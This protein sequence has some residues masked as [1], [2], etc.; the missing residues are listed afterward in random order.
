MNSCRFW[1]ADYS[2]LVISSPF[3]ALENGKKMSKRVGKGKNCT[4]RFLHI[5][6][7]LCLGFSPKQPN[8]NKYNLSASTALSEQQL[9]QAFSSSAAQTLQDAATL[10]P[11]H[12]SP[13]AVLPA[14]SCPVAIAAQFHSTSLG[15]KVTILVPHLMNSSLHKDKL[16]N[17]LPIKG[18]L[19]LID[20]ILFFFILTCPYSEPHIVFLFHYPRMFPEKLGYA[21]TPPVIFLTLPCVIPRHP[22]MITDSFQVLKTSWARTSLITTK[23]NNEVPRAKQKHENA[24]ILSCQ[25]PVPF[26]DLLITC[27]IIGLQPLHSQ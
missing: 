8:K 5:P 17:L 2:L 7:Q 14:A 12:I 18:L 23:P 25:T 19:T 1:W 10:Q 6:E 13:W 27:K 24:P 4:L 9:V 16:K 26:S 15:W 3:C 11:T 20:L 21:V 22:I